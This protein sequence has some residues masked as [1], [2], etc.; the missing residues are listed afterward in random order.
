MANALECSKAQN[1]PFN[2]IIWRS[3]L[4]CNFSE[5]STVSENE[6]Y[7]KE[8]WLRSNAHEGFLF[9]LVFIY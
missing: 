2:I 7:Y 4:P 9:F 8:A 5:K 6:T 1:C 3:L